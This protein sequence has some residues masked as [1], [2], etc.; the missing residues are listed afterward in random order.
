[1]RALVLLSLVAVSLAGCASP[2]APT[3]ANDVAAPSVAL[4]ALA[5][6][7]E[8]EGLEAPTFSVVSLYEGGP[9]AY[10]AGEPNVWAALD[11]TLYAAFAG[12]DADVGPELFLGQSACMHGVVYRSEDAGATWTRLNADGTGALDPEGTPANG[13]NDVTVDAAGN[14]Y[15]SNLGGGIYVQRLLA[16]EDSWKEVGNVVPDEHWAD[17][18]WMAASAPG[19]LVVAWM[20]GAEGTDRQV[21]VNTTFDAGETWTGVA[22]LG[23]DIGWLGSVQFAPDGLSAYVP[24]TQAEEDVGPQAFLVGAARYHLH[25]ARTFD[26]GR[27]W[28]VV[29]TGIEVTTSGTGGHWSG[30]LMAPSLDVTGDGTLVYAWAE[31]VLDATGLTSTGTVVKLATSVDQGATWSAPIV[32]SSRAQSIMP[33]VT[34]GAGDRV[35]IT[36]LASDLPGDSDYVGEWDVSA[37]VVDA[38]ASTPEVVETVLEAAVHTGG[39]CSKGGACLLTGSDRALL[40]FFESD[41]LPDGRLVVAYMTDPPTT[42]KALQ[43]RVAVQDGGSLLLHPRVASG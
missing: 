37:V 31:D 14:V 19:H 32:V 20:G 29:D 23:K 10:G 17:R 28:D 4:H 2:D 24:F 30:V 27:A 22:Y 26:G 12:C 43:L 3:A 33:W 9:R 7:V 21:A 40:D 35:A 42:G 16:G 1:M 25:V 15:V 11:G 39:I 8:P 34:G 18:Q 38:V 41:L 5:G 13:D 36:F 6:A